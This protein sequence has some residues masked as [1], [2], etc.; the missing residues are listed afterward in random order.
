MWHHSF[1]LGTWEKCWGVVEHA[2]A[3][4]FF[5]KGEFGAV[6]MHQRALQLSPRDS[7]N[8]PL[9][10][11]AAG[12]EFNLKCMYAL[13]R[14]AVRSVSPP[15]FLFPLFLLLNRMLG[16]PRVQTNNRR[17][18]MQQIAAG[19]RVASWRKI[20]GLSGSREATAHNTRAAP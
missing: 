2:M 14:Y 13:Q 19:E 11:T 20:L 12:L 7:P 17:V 18:M 3:H 1:R 8:G 6:D 15:F 5:G 9:F 4:P 16:M 10:A